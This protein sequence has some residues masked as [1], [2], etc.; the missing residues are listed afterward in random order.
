MTG[1]TAEALQGWLDWGGQ[2]LATWDDGN[3]VPEKV[4]KGEGIGGFDT[5]LWMERSGEEGDGE[6]SCSEESVRES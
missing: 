5:E 3:R 1:N 4:G 2:E 6:H